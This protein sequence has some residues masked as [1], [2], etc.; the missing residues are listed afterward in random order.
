MKKMPPT[1]SSKTCTPANCPGAKTEQ[2]MSGVKQLVEKVLVDI[3]SLKEILAGT[4]D[5]PGLVHQVREL[6]DSQRATAAAVEKLTEAVRELEQFKIGQVEINKLLKSEVDGSVK[7][8]D[9]EAT[10]KGASWVGKSVTAV[11]G[12][13]TG[14]FGMF[15]AYKA[16]KP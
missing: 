7:A 4:M 6:S 16:L 3:A 12:F 8:K 5:R 11:I 10:A 13:V 15:A 9:V 1:K 2:E 14:V